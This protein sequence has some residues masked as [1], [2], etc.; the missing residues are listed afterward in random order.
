ML[1]EW[2]ERAAI[3]SLYGWLAV[4]LATTFFVGQGNAGNLLLLLSEGIVVLLVLIRR[5]T[6]HI[7]PRPVDWLLALAATAAPM[8][9]YP[10]G[11][12]A[13]VPPIIG[14]VA[15]L[16]GL[17]IQVYAKVVLGRSFGCVAANRGLKLFG[18]YRYVRHPIYAGYLLGHLGFLLMN[19]TVWNLSVYAICYSLQIP[20][21]LAEE[22]LLSQDE[23]YGKYMKQVRFRLIPRVF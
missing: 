13:L 21:L 1:L 7:S 18:P 4:K 23:N 9:V 10:D 2:G 17:G 3:L 11:A 6:N 19:P 15:M 20:R 8:F 16:L 5:S 14:A 12:H 22:R